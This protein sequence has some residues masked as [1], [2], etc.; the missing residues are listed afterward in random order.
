MF[1]RIRRAARAGQALR[2]GFRIV[3]AGAPN[4]GKSSLL[5]R[6]TAAD[7]AIVDATPGTTRDTI[8]VET[9]LGG[10]YAAIVDTAGV[11]ASGDAVEREGVRRAL[12]ALEQ[13]DAAILVS[14]YGGAP[15]PEPLLNRVRGVKHRI[16]VHNKID[17]HGAT[18]YAR[19]GPDGWEIALCARTGDGIDGLRTVLERITGADDV[20]EDVLLAQARHIHALD[21]AGAAVERAR[22]LAGQGVPPELVAEELRLA[23]AALDRITGATT[24]DDLLGEIFSRFCVG[25]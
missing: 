25:K 1:E 13:A 18:P 6:L 12:R 5:N 14:E 21:D 7:R 17:L 11:R 22:Q 2:A 4:V 15:V 9:T 16:W 23:Q 19:A 8:E 24:A 10:I 20:E 3:I